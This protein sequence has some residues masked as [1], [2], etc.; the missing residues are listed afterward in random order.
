LIV[1]NNG[2]GSE[3]SRGHACDVDWGDAR[4]DRDDESNIRVKCRVN[5]WGH[6]ENCEVLSYT[7]GYTAGVSVELGLKQRERREVGGMV[8][9]DWFE[10]RMRITVKFSDGEGHDEDTAKT[11]L[12]TQ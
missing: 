1:V 9:R 3:L 8:H 2:E 7:V 12:G 10:N 5:G 11:E 6:G 4:V